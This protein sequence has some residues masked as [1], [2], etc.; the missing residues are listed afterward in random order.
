MRI[1]IALAILF[2]IPVA[3][4]FIGDAFYRKGVDSRSRLWTGVGNALARTGAFVVA[5]VLALGLGL[6]VLGGVLLVVF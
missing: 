5:A 2:L 3:L 4:V 6:G 1:V